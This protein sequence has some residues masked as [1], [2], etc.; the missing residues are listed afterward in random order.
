MVEPIQLPEVPPSGPW[1]AYVLIV[2]WLP[3][4]MRMLFLMFPFRR[5]ILRLAPHTGWAL[6]ALRD[7]PIKGIGLLV[8]N[9]IMAFMIP[10]LLVFGLRLFVDPVGWQSWDEVSNTGL[11]LLMLLVAMWLFFD[12][13]RIARVRRMLKAI[14]K[15]DIDRIKKVADAGLKTRT[16]LRRFAR[17]TKV[18]GKDTSPSASD[19]TAVV[20]QSAAKRWGRRVLLSRKITPAGLLSSGPQRIRPTRPHWR[21]QTLRRRGCQTAERVREHCADQHEDVAHAV[22]SGHGHGG[23]AN[24]DAGRSADAAGLSATFM[25]RPPVPSH[26]DLP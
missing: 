2:V 15:H 20:A 19:Q 14:E 16:F 25:R 21:W 4:V 18:K 12:V 3:L 26:E 1:A 6:K 5:A 23:V 22:R 8:A 11:A 9:E 24:R 7:L 10:P 17:K 13:L